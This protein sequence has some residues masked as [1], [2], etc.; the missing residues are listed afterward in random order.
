MKGNTMTS[1]SA[2]DQFLTQKTLAVVG[3]SRSGKKFGN[4][5]AK[6]L[7]TKGYTIFPINAQAENIDGERC[8]PSVKELP[9]SVGGVV[10]TVPP[11]ET[12]KVVRD[13]AEAGITQVWMQQGSESKAAIQFCEEHGISVV[14]G[15][16]LLMFA[17]P[18][19]WFHRI[20]RGIWRLLGKLP[21]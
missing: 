14:H 18:V 12:E 2:V 10:I 8:Y 5:V 7:K 9:E 4:A 13:V 3:V 21:R 19:A 6:E 11:A 16:C 17:E 15:E 20:H 1:K